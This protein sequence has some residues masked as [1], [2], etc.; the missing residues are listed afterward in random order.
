LVL[1][2]SVIFTLI[3]VTPWLSLRTLAQ[4]RHLLMQWWDRIVRRQEAKVAAHLV[5]LDGQLAALE[6]APG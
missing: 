5:D 2:P 6:Q 1:S 3:G 4:L